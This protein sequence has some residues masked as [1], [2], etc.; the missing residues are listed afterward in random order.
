[1]AAVRIW[2]KS[3]EGQMERDP[4][5]ET[6]IGYAIPDK[7]E[8]FGDAAERIAIRRPAPFRGR[9]R[10]RRLGGALWR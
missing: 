8:C 9:V 1:M 5:S 7:D 3:N 10:H 2:P 6:N 4:S